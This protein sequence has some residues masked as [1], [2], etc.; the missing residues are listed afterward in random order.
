MRLDPTKTAAIVAVLAATG[1]AIAAPPAPKAAGEKWQLTVS[2]NAMGMS[3]P[4]RTQEVC[5][6]KENPGEAL[7][8]QSAGD[9]SCRMYDVVHSGNRTTGK[10]E[11]KGKDTSMSGRVEVITE[12]DRIRS[13]FE[14]KM[15][16]GPVSIKN[17]AR[18]VGAACTVGAIA[19][20]TGFGRP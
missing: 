13:T 2:F 14:G 6:P 9:D 4:P 19:P 11:C 10:M 20:M 5:L 3:M 12:T 7:Q 17:D 15:A 1:A 18:R 8:K 16:D